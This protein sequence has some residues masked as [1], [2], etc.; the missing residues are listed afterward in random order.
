MGRRPGTANAEEWHHPS[1]LMSP[2][3]HGAASTRSSPSE[4]LSRAGETASRITRGTFGASLGPTA[5]TT[6]LAPLISSVPSGPLDL[7]T[8]P[9]STLRPWTCTLPNETLVTVAC[10]TSG[11]VE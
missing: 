7:T 9:S 4:S 11:A 3:L 6:A 5:S 8:N 2:F 1:P 10:A